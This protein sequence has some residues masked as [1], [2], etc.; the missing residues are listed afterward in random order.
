MNI[1]EAKEEIKHTL[2]AYNRKDAAG[3]YTFPKLRQ[4]PILLMGPPG[5]GKTAIMEQVAEECNVGLVAYTITHHTRQ[6]AVGLPRIVTRCYNGKEVSITEYTLSEIIASV[7]DCMERTGKKEGILF[8]DEINC[9][10]ETLAPTMLQFLQN[11]TFGSHSVPEGW[12]IAAAGNP[13]EYNKSV[14][15]FDIVTLD[16]VR[17]MDIEADLE[18]WME[19]A[20]KKE[21]HGSILAYLGMKKD[22]FYSVENTV[23]GKFFVTAR[24]W[25]DLSE[26]LK[27][28]EELG[29]EITEN[30]IGEY[31]CREEIARSFF[32]SYQ[33]YRKYG[34]DYG[35][36]CLL[37]GEMPEEE[38]RK[39]VKMA[40]DASFEERF[41]V[42]GLLLDGL[43]GSFLTY[44]KM[45]GETGAV[46]QEL[47]HLKAFLQDKKDMTA[48]DEFTDVKK[49]SLAVRLEAELLTADQQTTEE[50]VIRT[51]E[52]FSLTIRKEHITETEAGFE[53]I[54]QLF[55]EMAEKRKACAKKI[56]GELEQAF[57]FMKEC[58]GD[59]QETVLFVTG[60]TRNSHAAAFIREYGCDPYFACSEKLLYRKQEKKLQEECASLLEI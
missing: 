23:D 56:S 30:L 55:T 53:R 59:G 19:Y 44:E 40:K 21:I 5:I 37:S 18:V 49:K 28:Y 58:F 35:L 57:T 43:N 8:I 27:A 12:L 29:V 24:G 42:T 11:K 22:H 48:L 9:V 7:Y 4:R 51:L 13:P 38:Q 3:R 54:R 41:L 46:Y 32:A 25:E 60:L 33:L 47:L 2:L 50:L 34:E 10:S 52:E 20:W 31:L 36:E 6:S 14:R 17:R 39:K 15:E 26:I 16:R 45:D 1:K